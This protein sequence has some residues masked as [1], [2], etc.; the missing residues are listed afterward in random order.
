MIILDS[1]S[2]DGIKDVKEIN[3]LME[4]PYFYDVDLWIKSSIE[5]DAYILYSVEILYPIIHGVAGYLHRYLEVRFFRYQDILCLV[6]HIGK[7]KYRPFRY[8][9]GVCQITFVSLL[10]SCYSLFFYG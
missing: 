3:L 6:P 1:I 5:E 9:N 8:G 10:S 2:I 4:N 7:L